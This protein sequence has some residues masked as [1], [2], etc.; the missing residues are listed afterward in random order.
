MVGVVVCLGP[1]HRLQI[2]AVLSVYALAQVRQ[3]W[4]GWE[5]IAAMTVNTSKIK[6]SDGSNE[7]NNHVRKYYP[8]TMMPRV[9]H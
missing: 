6:N 3:R 7:G 9:E 1:Y 5:I 4:W 2:Y 8:H